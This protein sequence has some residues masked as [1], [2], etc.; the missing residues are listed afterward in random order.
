MSVTKTNFI[1]FSLKIKTSAF[2][3]LAHFSVFRG[4]NLS[5]VNYQN[6]GKNTR[7][8]KAF[9]M[10]WTLHYGNYIMDITLWTLN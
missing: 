4:P 9:F 3:S 6:P 7:K 5:A 10:L 1:L 8:N 2:V